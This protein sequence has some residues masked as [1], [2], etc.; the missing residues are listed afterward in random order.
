MLPSP[1]NKF[2][3]LGAEFAQWCDVE[4]I[5]YRN[6]NTKTENEEKS[7]GEENFKK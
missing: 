2:L 1:R 6:Q 7:Q 3:G 5:R 4:K